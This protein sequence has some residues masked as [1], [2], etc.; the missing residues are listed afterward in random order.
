MAMG[1]WHTLCLT[2]GM[3]ACGEEDP[4]SSYY[5][6]YIH[7]DAT[8]IEAKMPAQ[9]LVFN[10]GDKIDGRPVVLNVWATW[11]PPCVR[12]LPSLAGLAQQGEFDV[13]ALSVDNNAERLTDFLAR[14][15]GQLEKLKVWHQ[16]GGRQVAKL[17]GASAYPITYLLSAKGDVLAIYTG[18]REW[19][20]PAMVAKLKA[21]LESQVT[22]KP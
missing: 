14:R 10:L 6:E 2:L 3:A 1:L 17:L 11:C 22:E 12:E 7:V 13:I 19:D 9:P 21:V 16:P 18:P 20:D 4:R 8:V 5:R 15:E